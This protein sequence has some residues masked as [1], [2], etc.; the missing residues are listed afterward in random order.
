MK[1]A[2]ISLW[3]LTGD[4]LET[5]INIGYSTNLLHQNCY[6]AIIDGESSQEVCEQIERHQGN[7][8]VGRL[9]GRNN[10]RS[11]KQPGGRRGR[12]R[13]PFSRRGR[14]ARLRKRSGSIWWDEIAWK[15][16]GLSPAADAQV[17]ALLFF[18]FPSISVSR[19]LFASCIR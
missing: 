16:L 19:Q 17:G 4:K 18:L 11:S 1:D 7:C 13:A 8:N 15:E 5:A 9:I 3:V 12:L 2:G 10:L 14:R 6:N